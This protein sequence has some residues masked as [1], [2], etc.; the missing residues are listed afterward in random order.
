MREKK[1][2]MHRIIL[3]HHVQI[4]KD[5]VNEQPI[6]LSNIRSQEIIYID[7]QEGLLNNTLFRDYTLDEITNI[8]GRPSSTQPPWKEN[9][10]FKIPIQHGVSLVY[11]DK[12]IVFDFDDPYSD[13]EQH[14]IRI[15][16]YLTLTIHEKTNTKILGFHETLHPKINNGWKAKHIM[17]SFSEYQPYDSFEYKAKMRIYGEKSPLAYISMNSSEQSHLTFYYHIDTKFVEK[18]SV[19]KNISRELKKIFQ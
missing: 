7:L 19:E 9:I 12:G 1:L 5:D 6:D 4:T 14:L 15:N 8:F 11:A 17:Q 3:V 10:G 16:I 13:F 2:M 18:I